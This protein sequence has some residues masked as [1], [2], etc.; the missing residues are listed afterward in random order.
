VSEFRGGG[1]TRPRRR[2]AADES[3]LAE[4]NRGCDSGLRIRDEK[5]VCELE[6]AQ[7]RL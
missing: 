7:E 4:L 6:T 5:A 2:I 3:R 1:A